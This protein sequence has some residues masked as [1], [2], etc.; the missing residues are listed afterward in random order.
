MSTI[1]LE[2]MEFFAY[3]GCFEEEKIIG[4]RFIVD[5]YIDA[6][7]SEAEKTDDLNGDY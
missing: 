3:H 6:D 2:G 7:T 1:A 5:L 4:T